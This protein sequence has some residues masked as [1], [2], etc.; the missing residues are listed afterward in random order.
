MRA[1]SG[2]RPTGRTPP[3]TLGRTTIKVVQMSVSLGLSSQ[4]RRRKVRV[5]TRI[6]GHFS[7]HRGWKQSHPSA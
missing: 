2:S 3:V 4:D 5:E 1:K 7:T 6:E